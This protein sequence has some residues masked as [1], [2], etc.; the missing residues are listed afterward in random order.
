MDGV[1]MGRRPGHRFVLDSQAERRRRRGVV[2]VAPGQRESAA[3]TPTRRIAFRES[4][5]QRG[6]CSSVSQ[7]VGK[8]MLSPQ[9]GHVSRTGLSSLAT[10]S[11]ILPTPLSATTAA[12]SRATSLARPG[13]G[14]GP[15]RRPSRRPQAIRW[16]RR[17]TC[18]ARPPPPIARCAPSRR[19]GRFGGRPWPLLPRRSCVV[20]SSRPIASHGCSW[21][22][23]SLDP[24]PEAFVLVA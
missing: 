9:R 23:R 16:P 20:P 6:Q 13:T 12:G 5:T 22:R 7:F 15:G 2:S 11:V 17:R 24:E 18:G 14:R 21:C 4:A 8:L 3:V 19:H 10:A 1:R